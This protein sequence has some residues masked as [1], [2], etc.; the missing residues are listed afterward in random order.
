M[1]LV[2]CK[3]RDTRKFQKECAKE[4]CVFNVFLK[5]NTV[6]G[7]K[8]YKYLV[9]C[10]Q[11][12]ARRHACSTANIAMV[13]DGVRLSLPMLFWLFIKNKSTV[14]WCEKRISGLLTCAEVLEK[15]QEKKSWYR[16][17]TWWY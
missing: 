13:L 17:Y 10:A 7:R 8:N 12:S 2:H 11:E 15:F 4:P 3:H 9:V 1:L 6:F 16:L 5:R 14:L